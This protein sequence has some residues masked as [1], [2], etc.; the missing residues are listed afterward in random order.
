V[1]TGGASPATSS[2]N[3]TCGDWSTAASN[4]YIGTANRLDETWFNSLPSG[5]CAVPR[6]LYCVQP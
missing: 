6:R 2:G 5:N 4:A 1:F 3:F